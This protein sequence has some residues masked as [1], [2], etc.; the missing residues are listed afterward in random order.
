V[1]GE[2]DEEVIDT[3][4]VITDNSATMLVSEGDSANFSSDAA[5]YVGRADNCWKNQLV[6]SNTC[7]AIAVIKALN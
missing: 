5:R 6:V 7:T 2:R 1:I 4:N 3:G